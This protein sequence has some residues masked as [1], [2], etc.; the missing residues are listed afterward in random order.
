MNDTRDLERDEKTG[1]AAEMRE[2]HLRER[3]GELPRST[4]SVRW[5]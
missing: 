3:E 5:T 1:Y 4:L 2:F